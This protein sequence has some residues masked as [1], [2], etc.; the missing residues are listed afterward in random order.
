MVWCSIGSCRTCCGSSTQRTVEQ[1]F[2]CAYLHFK[3]FFENGTYLLLA[4]VQLEEYFF[5]RLDWILSISHPSNVD[6]AKMSASRKKN[7]HVVIMQK[8]A[9][10]SYEFHWHGN[11]VSL[12]RFHSIRRCI[13][14]SFFS[15]F[16]LVSPSYNP[17]TPNEQSVFPSSEKFSVGYF[18]V[19]YR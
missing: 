2:L 12:K 5:G 3:T 17:S 8:H 11:C 15:F 7:E 14:T 1:F 10:F 18:V 6:H 16:L 9:K 19:I 13:I 4:S